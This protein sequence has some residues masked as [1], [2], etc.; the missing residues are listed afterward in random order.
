MALAAG[1]SALEAITL[2]NLAGSI[3]VRKIGTT[4]TAGVAELAEALHAAE[5]RDR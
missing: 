3:V 1:A 4:G 5:G 2:A